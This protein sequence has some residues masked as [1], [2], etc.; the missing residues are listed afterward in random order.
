MRS[1]KE[2]TIGWRYYVGMHLG[3]C[4][5]PVDALLQLRSADRVAWSGEVTESGQITV[6]A[7]SLFGGDE[8]EGGLQG[9]VDVMMGEADQ[10][11]NA[12]LTEQQSGPQPGYRG[13]LGLVFRAFYWG[14]SQ[15][16]KPVAVLARRIAMGWN[17]DGGCWYPEKAEVPV[18]SI[19]IAPWLAATDP[20][21][22]TNQH[23]YRYGS[24]PWRSTLEAAQADAGGTGF[25]NFLGWSS[26]GRALFAAY[27]G[28]PGDAASLFLHFNAYAQGNATLSFEATLPGS[29]EPV[30]GLFAGS[31]IEP[32][33]GRFWWSGR[34]SDNELADVAS[35]EAP[36]GMYR[37]ILGIDPL[38][39]GELLGN[40]CTSDYAPVE[41]SFPAAVY[42]ADR[43][44]EVR[45]VGTPIVGMNP[46]HIVYQCL[47][48]PQWGSGAGVGLVDDTN[49]REAADTFYDE[50]LGLCLHWTQQEPVERLIQLV[51]DHAGAN[52]VQNPRTGL[53]QI[54]PLRGGY[55]AEALPLFDPAH[56]LTVER[57][58]R[59]ALDE[60]VNEVAATFTD[61]A[62]GPGKSGT[63]KAQNLAN[64]TAQ[65]GVV[66]RTKSY[67]GIPTASLA[68]RIAMRDLRA[69]SSP[70]AKLR[71]TVDRTAYGLVEGALFRLNWPKLGITGLVLRV[72][73]V[74]YGQLAGGKITIEA[75]EDV[76]GM[77]T[78]TY[79]AEQ[80][81]GWVAPVTT[82][83]PVDH[84]LMREANYY[85]AQLL[86][87]AT[88]AQAL[89]PTAT[90]LIAAAAKPSSAA[91]D[92][93]LW[94]RV[95]SEAYVEQ[96]RDSFAPSGTLSAAMGYTDTSATL[97]GITGGAQVSTGTYAQIDDEIVRVDAWNAT[98]GALTLGRGVL[99]TVAA[100][101][102]A[103]ARLFF[104][105]QNFAIDTTERLDGEVV[106]VKLLTRTGSGDL[107]LASA[108]T[109]TVTLA[110]VIQR[111]YPPGALLIA[112]EAYPES[113][114]DGSFTIS[115]A[116]RHR[117]QQNLEGD[118]SAD[119]GPES[120]V[121]YSLE[122]IDIGT[123]EVL[124]AVDGI[125]DT[126]YTVAD[127]VI[128]AG[129]IVRLRLWAVRADADALALRSAF[130]VTR[131]PAE[132]GAPSVIWRFLLASGG[133]VDIE[134]IVALSGAYF[135]ARRYSAAGVLEATLNCRMVSSAAYDSSAGVIALGTY[136]N[137]TTDPSE[138]WIIDVAAPGLTKISLEPDFPTPSGAE[139]I[140]VAAAGGSVYAVNYDGGRCNRYDP[141]GTEVDTV[142]DTLSRVF[143]C[144]GTNLV[145]AISGGFE[146]RDPTTLDS[147]G[148][149]TFSPAATRVGTLRLLGGE[150]VFLGD[151]SSGGNSTLYRYNATTGA[152]I[153]SYAGV[154]FN[155]SS[156]GADLARFAPYLSAGDTGAPTVFDTTDWSIVASAG[157]AAALESAQRHDYTF[158]V[159]AAGGERNTE[160]GDAR[161]AE[162]GSER[163][164]E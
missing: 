56:V 2:Q 101:H 1:K 154:P 61:I 57:M 139:R 26:D 153:A 78:T 62:A 156:T 55:D 146:R 85:E 86:L 23:E 113:I 117:T 74:N 21:S 17:T 152:R 150:V 63:V 103:G 100:S 69:V 73:R 71:I 10:A 58:E 41:G 125:D 16:L 89:D 30:C 15:Y 70:L 82:P 107:S 81:S 161:L 105:D 91:L 109:D 155:A 147:I 93:G 112:D 33:S 54:V 148:D 121:T 13:L 24:N 140:F 94:N 25:D 76:Y 11:A 43:I 135:E 122:L 123:D 118:E 51:I 90:Y 32:Y 39:T 46:A 88:D 67:P 37:L 20:R 22:S 68:S 97:T 98:T 96:G 131:E 35:G 64:I 114:T 4:E 151:P 108:P 149:V 111:P 133:R 145:F 59:P 127:G 19:A 102:A 48:D 83:M 49:F 157:A 44:I 87:G 6:D 115:W 141:D 158:S 80:P 8:R 79:A 18:G 53:F 31:D 42:S 106:D 164:R 119:I 7:P 75:G 104:V 47:T 9:T 36:P 3:I 110:A 52:L 130:E 65:G 28:T 72:L 134:S 128:G 142:D 159:T 137:P 14:T 120:G 99:G 129:M 92:F 77:P 66:S 84:R 34:N 60:A 12:Y 144:D 143:D 126:E 50:G 163:E 162:D 160:A 5:G 40:N 138:L 45:R 38:D 132:I 27:G 124:L 29:T 116:H 136:T 95:G